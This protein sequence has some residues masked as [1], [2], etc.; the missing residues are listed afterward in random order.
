MMRGTWEGVRAPCWIRFRLPLPSDMAAHSYIL[1]SGRVVSQSPVQPRL[2]L[3]VHEYYTVA[4]RHMQYASRASHAL[5][6]F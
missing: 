5:D 4:M 2:A 6:I 1:S 3:L